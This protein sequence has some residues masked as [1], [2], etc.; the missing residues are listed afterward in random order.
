MALKNI[1]VGSRVIDQDYTGEIQVIFV[2]NSDI[3]FVV[4]TGN[5]IAQLVLEQIAIA[6]IQVIKSLTETLHKDKGFGSTG[7]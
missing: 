5:C 4:N 3:N 6:D 2:N 1:H 7:R